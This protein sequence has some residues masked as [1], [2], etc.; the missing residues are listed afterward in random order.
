MKLRV[1]FVFLASLGILSPLIRAADTPAES[2]PPA[3]APSTAQ[4]APQTEKKTEL[5]IKMGHV[6]KALKKLKKQVGDPSKNDS[7]LEL[8]AT[9]EANMKDALNLTPERTA[10]LPEADR[11]KFIEAYK[12][13]INAMLDKFS[14]L[15]GA[16]AANNNGDAQKIISDIGPLEKKDHKQFQRPDNS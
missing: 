2:I 11:P 1:P 6:A 12:A 3:A 5:D 8:V 9:M 10:D 13:G 4:P 16:L 14:A 7:S 15:K